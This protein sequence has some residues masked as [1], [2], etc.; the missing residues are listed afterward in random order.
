MIKRLLQ[1]FKNMRAVF[2][3]PRSYRVRRFHH[4]APVRDKILKHSLKRQH[5]RLNAV[6]QRENIAM[7]RLLQIGQL[8]HLV[9]YF[10]VG[11]RRF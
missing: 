1:S 4:V 6:H 2:R 3:F 10:L 8:I 9:E 7:E 11:M 5:H